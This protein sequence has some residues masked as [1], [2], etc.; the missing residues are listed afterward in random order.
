MPFL[1]LLIL[2]TPSSPSSEW[3]TGYPAS[4]SHHHRQV[5]LPSI[6][7]PP[8]SHSQTTW[9]PHSSTHEWRW[10]LKVDS[11]SEKSVILYCTAHTSSSLYCTVLHW[12]KPDHYRLR[13]VPLWRI[14]GGQMMSLMVIC[15]EWIPYTVSVNGSCLETFR[16]NGFYAWCRCPNTDMVIYQNLNWTSI[17]HTHPSN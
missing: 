5:I 14:Y 15:V 7:T 16:I 11:R 12:A 2:H 6:V 8:K 4:H 17:H 1:L 9:L 3:N 13:S 10:N